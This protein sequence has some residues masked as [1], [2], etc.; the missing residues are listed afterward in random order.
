MAKKGWIIAG[1]L[2]AAGLAVVVVLAA[3]VGYYYY[4]QRQGASADASSATAGSPPEASPAEAQ[5]PANPSSAPGEV[6]SPQTGAK[7]AEKADSGAASAIDD[8]EADPVRDPDTLDAPLLAKERSQKPIRVTQA[9]RKTHDVA[10]EYPDVA[11]AARVQ[12]IVILELTVNEEGRVSSAKVLR[13]I[14]LLDEA[15]LSAVKQWRYEPT[16]VDGRAVPVIVT[17]T[18]NFRMQLG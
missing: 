12:G 6:S 1:C 3:A 13:S 10:P 5:P 16:L 15:A 4:S 11:S 7:S 8:I 18:V 14:P 9:P 2:A 17:V